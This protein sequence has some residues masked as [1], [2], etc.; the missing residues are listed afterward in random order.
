VYYGK[1]LRQI[2][3]ALRSFSDIPQHLSEIH[4]DINQHKDAV[5]TA[6]ELENQN[7]QIRQKWAEKRFIENQITEEDGK[8]R[9]DRSYTNQRSI[10]R[11]T[12]IAAIGAIFYGA[13]AMYQAYEMREAT[14]AAIIS[15]DS[16]ISINRPWIVPGPPR[17]NR[18]TIQEANL[19]WQ[20][21]GKTPAVALFSTAEYFVG[22]FPPHL[23]S[24]PEIE[25]TLKK[26][27]LET[28]QYQGFVA[29]DGRYETGLANTPKWD[30]PA[31]LNIHGCVWY[32]DVLSNTERTTEFFYT[33]FHNKFGF[34]P[35]E[36]I[37]VFYM[38]D[39]PFVYE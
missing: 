22:E 16:V 1:L 34:P 4:K 25:K 10:K 21:A 20:N 26:Q 11:A 24:C 33:A 28:W 15:A 5:H 30:G 9:D 8:R 14:R 37:S 38:Q 19:E 39:H 7:D 32:T 36:G 18:R 13:V 2:V 12:W 17:Q 23:R 31:S 29:Q 3:E 6:S 35:S 27:P